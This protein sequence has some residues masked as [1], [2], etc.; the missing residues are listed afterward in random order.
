MPEV[1]KDEHFL[2]SDDEKVKIGCHLINKSFEEVVLP[3]VELSE[4]MV[5][6]IDPFGYKISFEKIQNLVGE[7]KEFFITSNVNTIQNKEELEQLHGL[8]YE[9]FEGS[10]NTTNRVE[11]YENNLKENTSAVYSLSF[12]V[13]KITAGS[14]LFHVIFA[15]RN[16]DGFVAIK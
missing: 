1:R 3:E 12:K 13:R 4:R 9:E 15:S 2:V 16:I 10:N 6:Y 11:M 8:S 14:S 7:G 5:S